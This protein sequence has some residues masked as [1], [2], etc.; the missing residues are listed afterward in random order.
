MFA[1]LNPAD[2]NMGELAT[3]NHTVT[4]KQ[5]EIL[6]EVKN[7]YEELFKSKDNM[8]HS[9]NLQTLLQGQNIK[10]ITD[11]EDILQYKK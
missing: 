3:K 6:Q 10:R 2:D 5:E 8:F 9:F 1:G 11:A 4:R 7:Y